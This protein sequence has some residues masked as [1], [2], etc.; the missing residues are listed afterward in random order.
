MTISVCCTDW[1]KEVSQA[2]VHIDGTAR[3]QLI[4]EGDNP[5]Y[6]KII[7]EYYN[8]T[9]IPSLLNTSFNIHGEPIV[10]SPRDAI[11]TFKASGLD[12]LAMGNFL[13]ENHYS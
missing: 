7:K 1:M 4:K 11:N 6:Y 12:Y 10:C 13:V 5:F 9:G 2:A 3:P 8:H